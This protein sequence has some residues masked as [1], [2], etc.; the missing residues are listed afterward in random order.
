MTNLL[1]SCWLDPGFQIEIESNVDGLR[2]LSVLLRRPPA[3]AYLSEP[4]PSPYPSW[5]EHVL[6]IETDGLLT[7]SAI[8]H[9]LTIAGK[10]EY[11]ECLAAD[12]DYMAN[13]KEFPSGEH[14]HV[15][16]YPDHP[17]MA[18]NSLAC[19]IAII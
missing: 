5:V 12:C 7:I 11:L 4:P 19:I 8:E 17:Y 9:E 13:K 10:L 16:Y 2:C 1:L 3:E 6:I 14:I 18:K 15:E